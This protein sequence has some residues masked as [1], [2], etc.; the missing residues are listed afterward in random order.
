MTRGTERQKAKARSVFAIALRQGKLK[1]P[2][3]CSKCRDKPGND[4]FGRPKI[5]A[6][7]EDYRKPLEVQWL[8]LKC[9]RGRGGA[10]DADRVIWVKKAV[11]SRRRSQRAF[12][13]Q[14][15]KIHNKRKLSRDQ[16]RGRA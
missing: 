7:H 10:H 12:W 5:E 16:A 13:D 3:R 15:A 11:R 9:H 4:N 1:R 8:C 2:I 14:H 6:H